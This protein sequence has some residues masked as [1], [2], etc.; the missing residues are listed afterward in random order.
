MMARRGIKSWKPV[1]GDY[2]IYVIIINFIVMII[3]IIIVTPRMSYIKSKQTLIA[4]CSE[5]L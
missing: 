2:I 1:D 5:S 3:S 4:T